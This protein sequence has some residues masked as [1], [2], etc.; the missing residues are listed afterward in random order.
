MG[1]P[2]AKALCLNFGG[3]LDFQGGRWDEAEEGLRGAVKLYREVG[4]AAGE[5]L[6][7]QRLGVLLTARGHLEESSQ[8]LMDG[9]I[10]GQRAAMRSHCLT[11]LHASII[12]NRLADGDRQGIEDSL[13]EGLEAARRHGD[14]VTCNALLVP[15]AV[16]AHIHLGQSEAARELCEKLQSTAA[17]FGSQVWHAMA[18]QC[19]G[20]V[21]LSE[22]KRSKAAAALEQA[23]HGYAAAGQPYEVARCQML[24]ADCISDAAKAETMRDAAAVVFRKLAAP[25]IE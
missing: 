14:C 13:A 23:Q 12:R 5:A 21:L 16:R 11:R 1:A 10:V 18:A 4:S 24:L 7:L 17:E 2:R 3:A 9:L 20:R 19:S 6:S 22:G 15:E 8:V 25:G